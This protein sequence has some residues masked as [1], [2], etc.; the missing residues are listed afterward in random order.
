MSNL[1]PW[2]ERSSW[3]RKAAAGDHD[4]TL[5]GSLDPFGARAKL[6]MGYSL[7][8]TYLLLTA[9]IACPLH[10]GMPP[11]MRASAC[12]LPILSLVVARSWPLEGLA[13]RTDRAVRVRKMDSL[14]PRGRGGHGKHWMLR[15]VSPLG[16]CTDIAARAERWMVKL[17]GAR[18]RTSV[19]DHALHTD[20]KPQLDNC[21]ETK[22]KPN[23]SRAAPCERQ[24]ARTPIAT[25]RIAEVFA[26]VTDWDKPGN[27]RNRRRYPYGTWESTNKRHHGT[28][29]LIFA[30]RS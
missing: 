25:S 1:S 5:Q 6:P 9:L 19:V 16:C 15:G 29:A 30:F 28:I 23:S 20:T 4:G 17:G 8:Y 7:D 3:Y 11:R 13:A 24:H 26:H 10:S 22:L 21:S 18:I 2:L 14:R 27:Q 12:I